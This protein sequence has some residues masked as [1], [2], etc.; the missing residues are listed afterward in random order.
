MFL[1]V[2]PTAF[3]RR[4]KKVIYPERVA[5]GD[6]CYYSIVLPIIKGVPQ[7]HGLIT[8]EKLLLPK[9]L[10]PPLNL[11]AFGDYNWQVMLAAEK[12]KR[13]LQREKC[14]LIFVDEKGNYG[15]VLVRLAEWARNVSVYTRNVDYYKSI[16]REIYV[17]LGCYIE[18]NSAV[19]VKRGYEFIVSGDV[20]DNIKGNFRRL[21]VNFVGEEDLVI[22]NEISRCFPEDVSKCALSEALYSRWEIGRLRD[23]VKNDL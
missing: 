17:A 22:P 20:T 9:G 8:D 3:K 6:R 12:L 13:R 18:V 14:D 21:T 11:K 16:Q 15:R 19:A 7:W 2:K 5:A 4:C 1:L 23:Y 10:I